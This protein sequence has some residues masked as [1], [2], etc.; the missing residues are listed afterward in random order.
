M[1]SPPD[2]LDLSTSAHRPVWALW[3]IWAF[4]GLLGAIAAALFISAIS[5]GSGGAA[6]LFAIPP[7]VLAGLLVWMTY[8]SVPSAML[9]LRVLLTGIGWLWTVIGT[10][11]ALA[12][13]EPW[14]T[15]LAI[16]LGVVCT[17]ALPLL[18]FCALD[19]W[20]DHLASRPD[21]AFRC[22]ACGYDLRATSAA[23]GP[24]LDRCPE[25]GLSVTLSTSPKSSAST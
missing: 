22:L 10:V 13:Y 14:P 12:S 20:Q 2:S 5:F 15:R 4:V 24:T 3:V 9:V 19:E 17:G 23:W 21:S 8:R 6:G 18:L 7:V 16:T 1:T 25:C 11:L